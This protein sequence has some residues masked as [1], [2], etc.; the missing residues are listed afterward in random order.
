LAD[1]CSTNGLDSIFIDLVTPGT[2]DTT[3]GADVPLVS[4][5]QPG[6]GVEDSALND[7]PSVVSIAAT[8]GAAPVP[9]AAVYK[10]ISGNGIIDRLDIT[11]SADIGLACSFQSGD[12][13]FPTAGQVN[14][15]T[16]TAC[17]L[18][19]NDIRL[20]VT[21]ATAVTGGTID[22]TVRYQDLGAAG[23]VK[24]GAN[25]ATIDFG[26]AGF[27]LLDGAAPVAVSAAYKD[28]GPSDFQLTVDSTIHNDYGLTY[29]ATYE[30]SI[31]AGSA[32]L[33]AFKRSPA[34]LGWT[35]LT[36][37][38]TTDFFNGIEA[39]RFDYAASRV[40]VS[41]AFGSA[42]DIVYLRLTDGSN[43]NIVAFYLGTTK[44]YDNRDAAVVVTADD[45]DSEPGR[46]AIF[47]TAC[48]V[49][50]NASIWFT[51]SI[52]TNFGGTP[53]NWANLQTEIDAG[54]VEPASHSQ[55]HANGALEV[56]GS[57]S[58]IL[59]NLTMPA[60]NKKGSTEY[61][62]AWIE[63]GGTSDAATRTA[64][65]QNKYLADRSIN[66]APLNDFSTWDAVN[67][68]Y[69]RANTSVFGDNIA[70]PTAADN[71]FDA[72]VA[73]NG[74]YHL[75]FHPANV[76]LTDGSAFRNHI[77]YIKEKKNLWYAGFGHLHLYHY[78]DDQNL[79]TVTKVNNFIDVDG[80][81]DSIDITMSADTGLTCAYNV[82]DWA[83]PVPGTVN[84]TG[85]SNCNADSSANVITLPTTGTLANT[86]GGTT[87]PTLTYTNNANRITDGSANNVGNFGALTVLDGA[88]PFILATSPV[89]A[90]TNVSWAQ[91][92]LVTFSEP[93][94]IG[95]I[96]KTSAP[97]PG[98]WAVTGTSGNRIANLA[99][100][101]LG[102]NTAYTFT[103]TGGQDT[104]GNA[105]DLDIGLVPNPWTFTSVYESGGGS[106]PP[107]PAPSA[108]A[109]AAPPAATPTTPTADLILQDPTPA[110]SLPGGVAIGT[111]VKRAD[112]SAVYFIDQDNRR[113][114]FP[115][116]K[117]YHS[118][119]PDFSGIDIISSATLA[120]I[121][122]GSNVT[123]RPGT[124]LVKIQSDPKVYAVE[125]YG[126]L[127]WVSTEQIAI[128][129]Y[130]SGWNS[131]IADVDPTFFTN[132]Q[133]GSAITSN[134]H[135]TGSAFSYQGDSNVYYVDNGQKR[136]ISASV[137]SS[138]KFQDKFIVRD[139][140]P[141][142]TYP[143]GTDLASQGMEA[144]MTLR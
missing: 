79:V 98:G 95:T 15:Q 142:I 24:D 119:Y 73:V 2:V 90:A 69:N 6:N 13:S 16:P 144:I 40:Y 89:N 18:N 5:T 48:T 139:V 29:P 65:G 121:P 85:V 38:T 57:K 86:T 45:W 130:G 66:F 55:T 70:D 134:I 50:R 33:K 135:P 75:W 7:V 23:S 32:G 87:A 128:S 112:M 76:N 37:K 34:D 126:V 10:D 82:A 100:T 107:A 110:A 35:Q 84:I 129:L 61:L 62:Y 21:G 93:M 92:L 56:S 138:N 97:D 106:L 3:G 91:S 9:L 120:F 116:E 41:V 1:A 74:I 118:Y 31:P 60:L 36:E 27:A 127:R 140:N 133:V 137:Y 113:H 11:M 105:L 96:T 39:V 22:P 44:F 78:M 58:D 14:P 8:D 53:A 111:L 72:T 88:D 81:V 131:R 132:Y 64:L 99:H 136:Y 115:N 25:N 63:P 94:N 117:V 141:A 125:P 42:S 143:G 102:N 71:T 83:V 52:I 46:D 43:V 17:T 54:Y 59:D 19:G 114:A 30:F 80:Q 20:A 108:P 77:D 123:M 124:Y 122:L 4:Y 49:F 26:A 51:P 47:A 103:I 68:L 28:N 12:W 101:S 104:T 67:G 109:P